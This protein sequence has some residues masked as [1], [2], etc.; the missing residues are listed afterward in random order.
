MLIR[1]PGASARV[2]S[3]AP[4]TW[5]VFDVLRFHAMPFTAA[6]GN[7]ERAESRVVL[8]GVW[9]AFR[10]VEDNLPETVQK[11][12]R[13]V[14][15]ALKE[16]P[17]SPGIAHQV[18][19]L[20]ARLAPSDSLDSDM[21]RASAIA[22]IQ[23][24]KKGITIDLASRLC[25]MIDSDDGRRLYMDPVESYGLEVVD[26]FPAAQKDIVCSS[27]CLALD[28]WTA[29][30]FHSM[31]ILEHGL[32]HLAD[33]VGAVFPDSIEVESW[34]RIIEKIESEIRRKERVLKRGVEKSNELRFYA[35]AASR[36]WHFK[37]AW[38]N[39]VAHA[40]ANYDEDQARDIFSA[41]RRFMR[42]MATE[43]SD[44]GAGR[45]DG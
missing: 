19:E 32:R 26:R 17:V 45:G 15:D 31:R 37:E 5:S 9:P 27:Q 16:L 40:R 34:Q 39:H 12:V 43:A 35:E 2:V 42:Q 7:L 8:S 44:G 24:I 18:R 25:F 20:E 22:L 28:Q 6:I 3:G 41:V 11:A 4:R 38:R 30:V 36:F 33:R 10:E 1:E 21:L 14:S 29:A 13:D 23:S